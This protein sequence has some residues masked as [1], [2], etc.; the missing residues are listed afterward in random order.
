MNVKNGMKKI[1]RGPY[2][3]LENLNGDDQQMKIPGKSYSQLT[4]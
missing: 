1:H 3:E 4:L 2:L